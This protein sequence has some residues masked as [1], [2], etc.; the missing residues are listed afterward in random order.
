MLHF[1]NKLSNYL[2]TVWC[3]IPNCIPRNG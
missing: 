3:M 1:E 2:K